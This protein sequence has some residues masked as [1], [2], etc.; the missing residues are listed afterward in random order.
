MLKIV[1]LSIVLS[2]VLI[3]DDFN[4]HTSFQGYSGIMNTPNASVV[5]TGKVEAVFSNQVSR[6]GSIQRE[7]YKAEDYI[8]NIGL[9]PY[10]EIGGRL[11]EVYPKDESREYHIRDL[12]ANIK[13]QLPFFNNSIYMPKIAVGV[14]DLGGAASHYDAKYLVMSKEFYFLR[15]SLGYGYDSTRLD[16]IFGGL[17]VKLSDWF[18]ILA[19]N[20]SKENHIGLKINTP[21]DFFKYGNI[22]LIAKK[23]LTYKDEDYSYGLNL[24]F[25]LGKKYHY[26]DEIKEENFDIKHNYENKPI[27][28][29]KKIKDIKTI[30]NLKDSLVEFGF[31]NIDIGEKGDAIYV[32]YENHIMDNNELDA[33]GVVL[34][35]ISFLKQYKHFEIVIKKSNIKIRKIEG[36]LTLYRNFLTNLS[37]NTSN[38]FKKSLKVST[39]FETTQYNMK[40]LSENS[41]YFKTRVDFSP[42]LTT[43]VG[44]EEG[45]FDYIAYLRTHLHWNLYKGFN[46]GIMYDLALS[47]SDSLDKDNGAF[48]YYNKSS[49][50]ESIMLHKSNVF[51][52]FINNFSIGSY[53]RDYL[54]FINQS[55][56][57]FGDNQ[58]KLKVAS[59]KNSGNDDE[60]Q[61]N[62][63]KAIYWNIYSSSTFSRSSY[64]N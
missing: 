58:L 41:G 15:A 33:I 2:S 31:E 9:F 11:S 60:E 19:E 4:T 37:K 49:G 18:Y 21:N 1:F 47:H 17:E 32:A 64:R 38:S 28:D 56:Y 8:L 40:V 62:I 45:V 53:Q 46:F 48:R 35:Y 25:N 51:G 29:I 24:K 50:I 42:V 3:S 10:L 61:K 44:S 54:G 23:N 36:D 16:G 26:K 20:D 13:F 55:A 34:G 5:E 43:F 6:L 22:A 52:N 59:F 30:D 12:S 7:N 14:Q 27:S 63:R 57:S 39:N